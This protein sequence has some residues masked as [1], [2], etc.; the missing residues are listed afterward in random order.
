M[1]LSCRDVVGIVSFFSISL[2]FS[3]RVKLL[4]RADRGLSDR[5]VFCGDRQPPSPRAPVV[6]ADNV[7]TGA[8]L[9]SGHRTDFSSSPH[10]LG[11]LRRASTTPFH[12]RW[13]TPF[14]RVAKA[15]KLWN[16]SPILYGMSSSTALG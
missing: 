11:F 6:L 5:V 4:R 3:K 14:G 13:P 8:S 15:A 12:T 10:I 16:H 9:I 1:Y 2:H 7:P